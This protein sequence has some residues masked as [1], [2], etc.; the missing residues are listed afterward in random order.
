MEGEIQLKP[1]AMQQAVKVSPQGFM[2]KSADGQ[3]IVQVRQDGFT[4]NWLRPYDRWESLRDEARVHW[5]RYRDTFR[6]EEVTR[7]GLRYI[8]RIELP[9]PLTDFRDYV[10]TAPDIAAGMPQGV[11]ALFMR[12][13]IPDNERRL[14]AIVTETLQ[15]SVDDDTRIPIIF[16]IDVVRPGKF[17]PSEPLWETLEQMHEYKNEIFFA[18]MTERAKEMFR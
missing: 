2:F 15:P 1:P 9:L 16:D 6:P 14:L 17:E 10:K 3:R 13:E 8:N 18:S 4:F 11:S 5:N 7:L 12:L